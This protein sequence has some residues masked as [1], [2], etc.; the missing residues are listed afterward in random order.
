MFSLVVTPN[1]YAGK[2]TAISKIGKSSFF[3]LLGLSICF[4]IVM[5]LM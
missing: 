1:S 3:I 2:I 4:E 5:K